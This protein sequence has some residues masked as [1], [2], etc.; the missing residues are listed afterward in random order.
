MKGKGLEIYVAMPS[1]KRR[2]L[3][4]TP[5]G[6]F[7]DLVETTKPHI[8]EKMEHPFHIIKPK[9]VFPKTRLRGMVKNRCQVN[10]L[11]ALTNQIMV[12]H[13]LI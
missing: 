6:R 7:A 3:P 12:R 5:E 13:Q 4:D 10:V 11:A 8:H 9:I 2:A 1:G